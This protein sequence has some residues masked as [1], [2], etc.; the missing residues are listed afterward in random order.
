MR[1]CVYDCFANF[2]D[3][4]MFYIMYGSTFAVCQLFNKSMID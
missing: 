1:D 4:L 3:H 2:P